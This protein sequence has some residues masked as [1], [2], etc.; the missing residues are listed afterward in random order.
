ME[1][2]GDLVG[3]YETTIYTPTEELVHG[4]NASPV[5]RVVKRLRLGRLHLKAMQDCMEASGNYYTTLDL[6]Y[7]IRASEPFKMNPFSSLGRDVDQEIP[8][9]YKGSYS[10]ITVRHDLI[11]GKKL[12]AFLS[13][14]LTGRGPEALSLLEKMLEEKPRTYDLFERLLETNKKP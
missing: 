12:E 7:W 6:V 13:S 5:P 11:Y 10:R 8:N 1:Q 9:A 4:N 3:V 2:E 14:S